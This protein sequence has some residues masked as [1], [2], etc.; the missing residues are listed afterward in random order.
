MK[1][2]IFILL[3]NCVVT[4]YLPTLV[5][6]QN[7]TYIGLQVNGWQYFGDIAPNANY[8]YELAPNKLGI[9]LQI[10]QLLYPRFSYRVSFNYGRIQADDFSVTNPLNEESKYRYARNLHFRNDIYELAFTTLYEPIQIK[11][12]NLSLYGLLGFAVFHHNPQAKL[13]TQL[14]SAWID[15]QPLQ[16]EGKNYA[17]Y[18]MAIPFGIGIKY[19]FSPRVQIGVELGARWLFFDY[20]DDIGGNYPDPSQLPNEMSRYFSDR[21]Q[22]AI[23]AFSGEQRNLISNPN[24]AIIGEKRGNIKNNDHY[25]LLGVHLNYRIRPRIPKPIKE[26]VV[27][28]YDT[29]NQAESKN[30]DDGLIMKISQNPPDWVLVVETPTISKIDTLSNPRPSFTTFWEITCVKKGREKELVF[31]PEADTFLPETIAKLDNLYLLLE[32]NPAMTLEIYTDSYDWESQYLEER[33]YYYHKRVYK[34]KE[35]LER[36]GIAAERISMIANMETPRR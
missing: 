11:K 7:K 6:A 23:S 16:T 29:L 36:K 33:T 12:W 28:V 32:E 26:W 31:P 25:I 2:F 9:G 8:R 34:V 19:D 24:V 4:L 17:L 27:E 13:P 5:K 15:L 3:L 14:G 35:Y 22:E 18:Q 21:S 1:S 30:Y 10:T 20:L